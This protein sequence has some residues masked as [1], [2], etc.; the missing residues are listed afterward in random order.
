MKAKPTHDRKKYVVVFF[1]HTRNHSWADVL[2]V[3]PINERPLPIAHKTYDVALEMV[4]DLT[5]ARRFIM[6]KLAVGMLHIGD[7]LHIEV[8]VSFSLAFHIHFS[9]VFLLNI[10]ETL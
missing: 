8:Y 3:R 10:C 4:K 7:Q 9:F 6:Q 1:P 2:L 5:I